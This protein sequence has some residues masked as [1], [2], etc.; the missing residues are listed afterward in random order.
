LI[1]LHSHIIYGIDDGAKDFDTAI[2][3]GAQA[4]EMGIKHIIATPHYNDFVD[5]DFFDVR[6]K[7]VSILNKY[8]ETK[9]ID[10]K[11]EAA[12]E[13]AFV[14]DWD[15]ILREKRLLIRDKF[16]LIEFP[17]SGVSNYALEVI[18]KV[19]KEG[20]IPIIAHPERCKT[21]QDDFDFVLELVRVGCHFQA[22]AGSFVGHFG[23]KTM[24]TASKFSNKNLYHFY[25]SDAHNTDLRNYLILNN[26]Y[27]KSY[28]TSLIDNSEIPEVQVNMNTKNAFQKIIDYLRY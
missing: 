27:F 14:S 6:D 22:D 12:A 13:V 26:D 11:I 24:K 17:D 3:M 4:V 20:Y 10:L 19:K 28:N 15:K 9:R 2:A 7:H 21:L 25:G 8:F 5:A 18:Y 23:R 1:D 16:I